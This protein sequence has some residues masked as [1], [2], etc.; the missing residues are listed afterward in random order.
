MTLTDRMSTQTSLT[1]TFDQVYNRGSSLGNLAGNWTASANGLMLTANAT[2][3]STMELK[4]LTDN[5]AGD[6]LAADFQ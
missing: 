1:L 4:L 6:F 3:G 5:D 2:A